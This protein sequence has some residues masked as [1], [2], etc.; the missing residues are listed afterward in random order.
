MQP[1][2]LPLA[3]ASLRSA[4]RERRLT[5]RQLVGILQRRDQALAA[6]GVWTH[7][8]GADERLAEVP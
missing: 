5:P 8:L 1:A 7:R 3:I 2:P 6:P 4:Y